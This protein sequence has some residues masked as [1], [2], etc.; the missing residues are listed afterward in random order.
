MDVN[1]EVPEGGVKP[2]KVLPFGKHAGKRLCDCPPNYL[3][4][5]AKNLID[6]DF[7]PYAVTAKALAEAED[8]DKK[9]ED[10]ELDADAFLL[11]HGCGH[12]V[13]RR[14]RGMK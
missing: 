10:T 12:L 5:V 6:S 9:S 14:R 11:K 7:A 3:R 4:W 8:D 1:I 2:T 13:P